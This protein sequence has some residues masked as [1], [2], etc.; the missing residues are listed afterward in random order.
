MSE[1]PLCTLSGKG[2]CSALT[3]R[4]LNSEND[5]ASEEGGDR[6]RQGALSGFG[7]SKDSQGQIETVEALNVLFVLKPRPEFWP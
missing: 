2:V 1:V 3:G 4:G 6:V 7:T 5:G